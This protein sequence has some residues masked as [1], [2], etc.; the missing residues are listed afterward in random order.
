MPDFTAPQ[1]KRWP[2]LAADLLLLGVA[3]AIV[4]FIPHGADPW[5]M[6]FLVGSVALAAWAGIAPFLIQHRTDVKFAECNSL[7]TVVEQ[8][9]NLRTFTNQI[10]FATAQ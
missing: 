1:L 6:L 9:N 4:R 3:L 7:A 5:W 8:L 2:F 10:S